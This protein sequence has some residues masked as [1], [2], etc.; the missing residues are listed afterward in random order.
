MQLQQQ[1]QNWL[2]EQQEGK[3]HKTIPE[4]P[5]KSGQPIGASQ[6]KHKKAQSNMV[7]GIAPEDGSLGSG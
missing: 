1:Q 7:H 6:L 2:R 5:P 4:Q 3:K